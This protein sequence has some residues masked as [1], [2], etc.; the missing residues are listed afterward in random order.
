MTFRVRRILCSGLKWYWIIL[1][2]GFLSLVFG[3]RDIVH[4]ICQRARRLRDDEHYRIGKQLLLK[5][6]V[7]GAVLLGVGHYLL[8]I[9]L[10]IPALRGLLYAIGINGTVLVSRGFHWYDG[11]IYAVAVDRYN[12][13]AHE[14][15][16]SFVLHGGTVIDVCCGSGAFA[17]RIA[18]KSHRV[19]G[20]DYAPSM[21]R[22]A[23]RQIAIQGVRNVEFVACDARCMEEIMRQGRFDYAV[24]SMALHEMPK[25]GA[26]AVLRGCGTI[27][28]EVL[29][30]DYAVPLLQNALGLLA[31][32]YEWIAGMEHFRQFLRYR[33]DGGLDELLDETGMRILDDVPAGNGTLRVVRAMSIKALS[34]KLNEEA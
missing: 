23:R 24:V 33:D 14:L 26:I 29:V 27:A 21:L 30:T 10:I 2:G 1:A 31:G 15:L 9:S 11:A 20:V 18:R 17:L 28:R 3:F 5:P 13:A 34:G 6:V 12:R 7:I 22:Y 25:K 16:E 8:N 32:Y 19:V 4:D